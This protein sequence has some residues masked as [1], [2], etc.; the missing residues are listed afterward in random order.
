M[1]ILMEDRPTWAAFDKEG[2]LESLKRGVLN[3]GKNQ[4]LADALLRSVRSVH[5]EALKYHADLSRV[6]PPGSK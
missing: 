6:V 4:Q 2:L 3:S 5:T 1:F